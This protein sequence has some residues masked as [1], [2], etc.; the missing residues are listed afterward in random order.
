MSYGDSGFRPTAARRRILLFR[1][2]RYP[3]PPLSWTPDGLT[4]YCPEK[5]GALYTCHLCYSI[6]PVIF[7]GLRTPNHSSSNGVTTMNLYIDDPKDDLFLYQIRCAHCDST[8]CTKVEGD[9]MRCH[10][11]GRA[12]PL[13]VLRELRSDA[14]WHLNSCID[15]GHDCTDWSVTRLVNNHTYPNAHIRGAKFLIREET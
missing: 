4:N 12:T 6:P 2:P 1:T 13:R 14:E 10:K 9:I 8:S 7:G 15:R 3:V 11:T 5:S